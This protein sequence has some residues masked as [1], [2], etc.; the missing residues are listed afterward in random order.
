MKSVFTAMTTCAGKTTWRKCR[1]QKCKRNLLKQVGNSNAS[2]GRR[3]A[4]PAPLADRPLFG[5]I[6]P[7]NSECIDGTCRDRRHEPARLVS[8][9]FNARIGGRRKLYRLK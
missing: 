5:V 6:A 2:S 4:P 9:V 7:W 3:R 1:R 8:R